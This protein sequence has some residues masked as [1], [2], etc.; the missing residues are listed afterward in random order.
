MKTIIEPF[1]IK[2]VVAPIRMATPALRESLR[3]L[4]IVEQPPPCATSRPA[5]ANCPV[6]E[7]VIG[8]AGT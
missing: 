5:S 2:K 6:P 7:P 3:G 4:E 8:P 1:R